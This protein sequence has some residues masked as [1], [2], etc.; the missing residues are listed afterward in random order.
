MYTAKHSMSAIQNTPIFRR[1]AL[2]TEK[3][4]KVYV[5]QLTNNTNN[6]LSFTQRQ[7]EKKPVIGTEE[8]V[9][10]FPFVTHSLSALLVKQEK[11]A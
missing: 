6:F 7:I 11:K 2:R 3:I 8:H 5:V 9:T 4:K 1:V 10:L